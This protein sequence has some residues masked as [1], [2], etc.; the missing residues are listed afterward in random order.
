M[1]GK[2][3][4]DDEMEYVVFDMDWL[5]IPIQDYPVGHLVVCHDPQN[6]LGKITWAVVKVA[7]A[8]PPPHAMGL[9]WDKEEAIRFAKAVCKDAK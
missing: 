9:F 1:S 5:D 6:R 7:S 3:G 2:L 8:E 4:P